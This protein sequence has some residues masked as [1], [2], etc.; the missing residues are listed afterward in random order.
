MENCYSN[1]MH[2]DGKGLLSLILSLI[3]LNVNP[4][5]C[6]PSVYSYDVPVPVPVVSAGMNPNPCFGPRLPHQWTRWEIS[7]AGRCCTSSRSSCV[8]TGVC[9]RWC[10]SASSS[11]RTK[12][13]SLCWNSPRVTHCRLPSWGGPLTK[14]GRVKD[15]PE[16]L[17]ALILCERRH[18]PSDFCLHSSSSGSVDLTYSKV[19]YQDLTKGLDGLLLNSFLHLVYLVTPY[20]VLSQ[21]KPDWMM[22][23]RQVE[24]VKA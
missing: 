3:G 22:Y 24:A 2:N 6:P 4:S 17:I 18:L 10:S 21:C 8:L 20:D 23:L 13:S 14:V 11:W 12:A 15:D 7:W 9:G 16:G 5:V 19:L 1:L